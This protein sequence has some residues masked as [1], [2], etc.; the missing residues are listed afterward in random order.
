MPLNWKQHWIL[1]TSESSK[2]SSWQ[3]I[4]SFRSLFG[5][6]PDCLN[7]CT[8]TF[9]LC[10][11]AIKLSP[12]LAGDTNSI[13]RRWENQ[14]NGSKRQVGTSSVTESWV[15][16]GWYWWHVY[17]CISYTQYIYNYIYQPEPRENVCA[18]SVALSI[19]AVVGCLVSRAIQQ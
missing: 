1:K 6:T 16:T 13:R 10:S 17:I 4:R 5:N 9:Q 3:R 11:K 8:S 15:T 7:H 2:N 18:H 12:K 19:A 14:Q